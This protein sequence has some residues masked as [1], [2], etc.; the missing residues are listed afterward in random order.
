MIDRTHQVIRI[1]KRAN[2]R[3]AAMLVDR[4]LDLRIHPIDAV[5]NRLIV[6]AAQQRAEIGKFA[7]FRARELICFMSTSSQRAE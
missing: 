7:P 3:I 2:V 4:R 5:F 6:P 1:L